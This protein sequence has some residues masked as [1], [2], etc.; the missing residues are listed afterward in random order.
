M[1]RSSP[2]SI[3]SSVFQPSFGLLLSSRNFKAFK[4]SILFG[5][6]SLGSV[7]ATDYNTSIGLK[8]VEFH[9]FRLSSTASTFSCFCLQLIILSG[10][11]IGPMMLLIAF[12]EVVS[13]ALTCTSSD[14]FFHFLLIL[15]LSS[16]LLSLIPH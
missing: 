4:I 9:C 10:L 14:F 2:A 8:R 1:D 12:I 13:F 16:S 7:P 11:V 5:S 3:F 6:L 15:Y